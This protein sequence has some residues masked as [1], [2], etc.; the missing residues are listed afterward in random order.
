V[1]SWRRN[2]RVAAGFLVRGGERKSRV[3]KKRGSF[4]EPGKDGYGAEKKK[5][6]LRCRRGN[7]LCEREN[8]FLGG[9]AEKKA[10]FLGEKDGDQQARVSTVWKNG[11]QKVTIERRRSLRGGNWAE[12]KG[13][14]T[15]PRKEGSER[16]TGNWLY[17]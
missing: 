4:P 11:T 2:G 14:F 17:F 16:R 12:G 9:L 8:L 3:L 13:H 5:M 15:I 6:A 10:V 1:G 7:N